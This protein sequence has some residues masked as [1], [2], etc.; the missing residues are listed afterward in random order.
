VALGNVDLCV[1]DFWETAERRQ[2]T[3]MTVSLD[4]DVFSLVSSSDTQAKA[5]EFFFSAIF[6]PFDSNV[7]IL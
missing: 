1:G 2:L 4:M 7:W 6:M 5:R 3:T